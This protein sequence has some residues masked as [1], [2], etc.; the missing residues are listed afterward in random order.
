LN[1]GLHLNKFILIGKYMS[2]GSRR[3]RKEKVY[4]V[5]DTPSGA[6]DIIKEKDRGLREVS[7]QT[8]V[9]NIQF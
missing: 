4:H 2:A 6:A 5:D 7:T 9:L 8:I 3:E 1:E